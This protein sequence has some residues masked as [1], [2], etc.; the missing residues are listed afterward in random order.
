MGPGTELDGQTLVIPLRFQR[1]GGRKRIVGPDGGELTPATKPQPDGTLMKALARAWQWQKTLDCCVCTSVTEI[2]EA[3]GIGKSYVS[4]I[5]R[6]AL[7]APDI[8]EASLAGRTYQTLMLERRERPL[9]ASW[10]EQRNPLPSH[11]L[12]VEACCRSAQLDAQ[13][14]MYSD[15]SSPPP[16]DGR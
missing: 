11:P 8:V 10:K 3:E 16:I 1:C 9:P 5:L 14:L 7:L 12:V 2:A 6:L 15:E 4:R 13:K